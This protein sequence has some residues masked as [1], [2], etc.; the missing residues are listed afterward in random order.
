MTDRPPD[1]RREPYYRDQRQTHPA[2]QEWQRL[3]D[4][5]AHLG[6]EIIAPVRPLITRMLDGLTAV[7]QRISPRR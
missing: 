7:L 3:H 6:R 4:A 5:M 1:E 2:T